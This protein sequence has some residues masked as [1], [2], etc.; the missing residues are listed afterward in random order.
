MA[1]K[2]QWVEIHDIVLEPDE[3]A[4]QAPEDTRKVP[5]EMFVK[6]FLM[7][8]A[9]IGDTVEIKTLTGRKVKGELIKD[10]PKH[11]H[12]F[13]EPVKELLEIGPKLRALLKEGEDRG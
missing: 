11:G 7:E 4:P 3:R 8:D 2:G 13:G 10:N 5:L 9:D 1:K 12:D 6:G